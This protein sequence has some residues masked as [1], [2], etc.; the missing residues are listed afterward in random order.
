MLVEITALTPGPASACADGDPAGGIARA[1]QRVT[2][3]RS[4]RIQTFPLLVN[5]WPLLLFVSQKVFVLPGL[6]LVGLGD[7]AYRRDLM[8]AA[9]M[10]LVGVLVYLGQ[11]PNFFDQAHLLGFISFVLSMPLV[12]YATRYN[13]TQ[14]RRWLTYLTLFNVAMSIYILVSNIDLY[15]FRGLNR[16]EGTDGVTSR[17]YF[18]SSSLAAVFL[19]STFRRRVLNIMTLVAVFVFVVFFARSAVVMALLG[20][21]LI[22]P[23][24]L[25]SPA[26]IKIG[27][28]IAAVVVAVLIYIYLPVIRPDIGLSLASKQFQ[29]DVII[30]LM[31]DNWTGWG[32]GS[33]LPPLATDKDQPYQIEMQLPMLMLQV[34]PIALIGI[35]VLTLSLFMSAAEE[36]ARGYARFIIYALIGFNN[37]WLFVP[38]WYLTCQLLFRD[39]RDPPAAPTKT[40]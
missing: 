10:T 37:P 5:V 21:N 13:P 11:F 36:K 26:P 9:G 19:L 39:E 25:R 40:R 17:I 33:Y 18:E 14:L 27:A 23:Y 15:G 12:N 2:L 38:S 3:W 35:L 29:L 32:W 28:T 7:A 16:I 1:Y 34:G 22:L 6:A 4:L 8:I 24:I 20:L 30:S 31:P